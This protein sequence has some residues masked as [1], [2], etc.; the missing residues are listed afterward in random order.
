MDLDRAGVAQHLDDLA[1]RVAADDRVVD[2]DQLLAADDVGQR[3]ELQPQAVLAQLL[4]GLDEG[5]RDVAVL[6]EAVVLRQP[7]LARVPARRGVARVRNRDHEIGTRRRRLA[8]QD[9]AHAPARGL[10]RRSVHPRVRPRE[11]DVLEH[12]ERLA[13]ALDDH[14]LLQPVGRDRDH[15]PGPYVAHELGADDVERARLAGHA[16]AAV[17]EPAERERAQPG[18]V[19]ERHDA[20]LRHRRRS[21]TRP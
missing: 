8:R 12:A 15:L 3:V 20:V 1:G 13:R 16:V 19:A 17:R 6:D 9:L 14:P 11:V 21:R 18:R 7:A 5:P 10:E 2:D 4:P